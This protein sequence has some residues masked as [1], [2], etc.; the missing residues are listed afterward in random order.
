MIPPVLSD[1]NNVATGCSDTIRRSASAW[2]DELRTAI[3]S[4]GELCAALGIDGDAVAGRLADSDDF[5]VLVPRSFVAR[6]RHGDATDPLLRQVLALEIE[7]AQVS[8]FVADPL[9]EREMVRAGVMRKYAR[10]ALL[11]TTAAC[12]VHCR[13]CFRRHFPYSEQLAARNA[14]APA[15]ES[16]RAATDVEEVILSGGDP[17]TLSTARLA[18]LIDALERIETVTTLRLHTRFPIIIPSRVTA[19]LLQML[20][21]TR[22][23]TVVVVHSNHANELRD[24]EVAASLRALAASTDLLLNQ[25]VL[26]S[27][28]NDNAPTL[29]ELSRALFDVGVTPYYLHMLDRVAGGAHFA[30]PRARA[31]AIMRK[32]RAELPGYLVPRLVRE[33]P[34]ALSKTPVY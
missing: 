4:A 15:L 12:P 29:C 23:R 3:R 2:R 33:E 10:R 26:L 13:Y 30:V 16:L 34:G 17:L 11:L 8:G 31:L 25:S 22:L 5:P 27:G 28:V 18:E 14:W 20:E 24:P 7:Q 21:G 9:S 19:N 1:P 32:L 6:M